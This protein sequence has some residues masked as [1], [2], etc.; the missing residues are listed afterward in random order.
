MLVALAF[1]GL[2]VT[3]FLLPHCSCT[4]PRAWTSARSWSSGCSASWS[5]RF[6]LLVAIEMLDLRGPD[7]DV[8]PHVLL[9]ERLHS[10][11][12][13]MTTRWRCIVIVMLCCRLASVSSTPPG[14]ASCSR[15]GRR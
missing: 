6:A 15:S 13:P 4:R 5:W 12:P 11:E 10:E 8:P 7:P 3:R 9:D 1:V 2:E 14:T